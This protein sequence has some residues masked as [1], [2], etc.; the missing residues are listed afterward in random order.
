[1]SSLALPGQSKD[2]TNSEV[3]SASSAFEKHFAFNQIVDAAERFL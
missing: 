3:D 1:V 2:S